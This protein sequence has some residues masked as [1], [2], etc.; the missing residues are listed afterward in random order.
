[1]I[2]VNQFI[3][4][5]F[6]RL[7]SKTYPQGYENRVLDEMVKH[8]LLP[9]NMQ[10]D[11]HGN[12]F[13]T[14]G[15]SRTI[16][17]SHLDTVSSKHEA[18][19]H[20]VDGDTIKTDGTTT[21][22]ADDKAG[23]CVMVWMIKNNIPGTYYFFIGEE[24]GCIGSGLAAKNGLFKGLYDR[25]ISF[26]RRG[27]N[28]IITHQSWSRCCSDAFADAFCD[29]LNKSGLSYIKDD[30]GVYTDSAEF[31]DLIPECTN[32]S[33]GYY[34]E[35]TTRE[36]QNIK[37]LIDLCNAC[38]LVE[39]ENL[40]TLRDPAIHESKSFKTYDYSSYKTKGE[41]HRTNSGS[42]WSRTGTVP[43]NKDYAYYDKW[44]ENEFDNNSMN[45]FYDEEYVL[46]TSRGKRSNRGKRG[47]RSKTY[48]D[49]G[50]SKLIE[51]DQSSDSQYDW[52]LEKFVGTSL[53]QKE[54][55]IIKEQYLDVEKKFI[56]S[57]YEVENNDESITAYILPSSS[58]SSNF[59]E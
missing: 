58:D 56:F 33:V 48:Y 57:T 23:V 15:N 52:I 55:E 59:Q 35:H 6:L 22:G 54:L 53:K 13:Y 49:A 16:F 38:I 21:L 34:S 47:K 19:T 39:W 17:A 40:P 12:Y 30:G 51:I 45:D 41:S 29:E 37:H 1:M 10:K 32:V 28:S 4:E 31:V 11:A 24:V 50:N 7:T 2:N 42:S 5:L 18:V 36:N 26:D 14:I 9:K 46:P 20:V 27:T 8:R 3:P 43:K 44:H 25:I